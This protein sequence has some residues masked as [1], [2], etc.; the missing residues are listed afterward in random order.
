MFKY[1]ISYLAAMSLVLASCGG[2]TPRIDVVCEEDNAG[3]DVVKWET[4]PAIEGNV[5]VYASLSPGRSVGKKPV[6]M[7]SI[8]RLTVAIPRADSTRRNYYTLVFNGKYHVQVASR[9]VRIPGIQ[10]FRDI[11]GYPSANAHKEVR[12]GMVYRSAKIDSLPE[13]SGRELQ[14][15]GIR[16]V[17]DLRTPAEAAGNAELP[18]GMERHLIPIPVDD[19]EEIMDDIQEENIKS[20]TVYRIV[21]RMNRELIGNHTGAYRELFKLLADGGNYPVLIQCSTGKGRTGIAVALLLHALGVDEDLIMADYCLSNVYYDI[22]ASTR[23]V[24]RLP[25][26]VQEAVTTMLSAR[27]SFLNAAE[28][29]A[30]RRYGSLDAYLRKGIGLEKNEIKKLRSILLH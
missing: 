24:Y 14:N 13:A 3:N 5:K 29:E 22:P 19:M 11:G 8:S 1:P 15:L 16:T 30:E 2:V 18:E 20:D 10:N 28:D 4:V 25:T 9:N 27:E 7:A 6:A 12:W 21:E 17:I 23:F 26:S